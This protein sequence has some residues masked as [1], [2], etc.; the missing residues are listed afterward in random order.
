MARPTLRIRLAL[1]ML[2]VPLCGGIWMLELLHPSRE[3]ANAIRIGMGREEVVAL[4]QPMYDDC[5]P[6]E[7]P[8]VD[9][10]LSKMENREAISDVA[11]WRLAFSLKH[12]WV[13]FGTDERVV[14]TLME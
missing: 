8:D 7:Y 10:T 1:A 2:A 9:A 4:L 5:P 12:L 14:S 3:A 13:G 11:V 6:G